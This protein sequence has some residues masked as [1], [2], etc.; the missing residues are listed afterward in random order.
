MFDKAKHLALRHANDGIHDHFF[1]E[2][3]VCAYIMINT[4]STSMVYGFI[5]LIS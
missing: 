3:E 2:P 4:D 5:L 1:D